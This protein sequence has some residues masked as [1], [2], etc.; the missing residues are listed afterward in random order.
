[1]VNGKARVG[2]LYQSIKGGGR[3]RYILYFLGY[4]NFEGGEEGG[5]NILKK[6]V[7]GIGR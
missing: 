4:F 1:M 2:N 3:K 6:S 5:V 7:L